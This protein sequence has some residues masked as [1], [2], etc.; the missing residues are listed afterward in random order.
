MH[1]S[2]VSMAALASAPLALAQIPSAPAAPTL[3][4][5][6]ALPVA[7]TLPATLP[8]TLPNVFA[9][10][11]KQMLPVPGWNSTTESFDTLA[12]LYSSSSQQLSAQLLAIGMSNTGR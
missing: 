1:L 12:G 5:A 2:I 6:P 8:T 10:P 7:P 4:S 3:P 9:Y 11:L